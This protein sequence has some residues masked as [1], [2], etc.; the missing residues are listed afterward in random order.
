MRRHSSS[1]GFTLVEVLVTLLLIGLLVGVVLPSVIGQA[2]RGETN[3]IVE[4]LESVRSGSK[5][6]RLDVNRWPGRLEHLVNQPGTWT[7]STDLFG[8]AISPGLIARWGGPY[9]EVGA[10]P[11]NVLVTA[12]DGTI[13]A[14]FDT[15]SWGGTEFLR[16]N[17]LGLT[18]AEGDGVNEVIDGDTLTGIGDDAAGRVR[19]T[20]DTLVYLAAPVNQ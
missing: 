9:L 16:V 3:R 10:L 2:A 8:N 11:D 20:T 13:Q 5:L 14:D 17:I 7:D 4:D 18:A 15:I 19:F 12:L 6:F 1:G